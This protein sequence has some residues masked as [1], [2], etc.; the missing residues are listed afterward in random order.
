MT[1]GLDNRQTACA[2]ILLERI[3]RAK[4]FSNRSMMIITY[5]DLSQEVAERY[6]IYIHYHTELGNEIGEIVHWCVSAIDENAPFI[7]VIVG[8]PDN[9][10]M[11]KNGYWG[12]YDDHRGKSIPPEKRDEEYIKEINYVFEYDWSSISETVDKIAA[13]RG[14]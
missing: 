11:P 2:K 8:S 10:F 5:K 12:L 9:S 1:L 6:G 7:S 14:M 4:K 13:A 3:S